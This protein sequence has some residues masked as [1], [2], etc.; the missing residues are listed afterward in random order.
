MRPLSFP[1]LRSQ[2][3]PWASCARCGSSL[4]CRGRD[5]ALGLGICNNYERQA[6]SVVLTFWKTAVDR[7][8]SFK[9]MGAASAASWS[10]RL[11]CLPIK[12]LSV[13]TRRETL[14]GWPD[15]RAGFSI[16][17]TGLGAP[18][19]HLNAENSGIFCGNRKSRKSRN[20]NP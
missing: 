17:Q 4:L 11:T 12:G 16:G 5:S 18:L 2:R 1:C 19:A 15:Q 20:K 13:N 14:Y 3:P 6:I 7:R 10:L 9:I 8:L